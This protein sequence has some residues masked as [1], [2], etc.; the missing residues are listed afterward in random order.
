[1]RNR[2]VYLHPW[3]NR[4]AVVSAFVAGGIEHL[5]DSNAND[6]VH[7]TL[8]ESTPRDYNFGDYIRTHMLDISNDVKFVCDPQPQC[9]RY[10]V[11]KQRYDL[12]T[13]LSR[14]S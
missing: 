13:D 7:V 3:A 2:V 6:I 10:E 11:P 4:D 12:T 5:V 14:S 8:P 1:M 9:A